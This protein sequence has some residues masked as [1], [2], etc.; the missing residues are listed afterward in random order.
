LTSCRVWNRPGVWFNFRLNRK[1]WWCDGGSNGMTAEQTT[2]IVTDM[3]SNGI[4]GQHVYL[5][6]CKPPLK[7]AEWI[8]AYLKKCLNPDNVPYG[9]IVSHGD[10][11][12]GEP[13]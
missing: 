12:L 8:A 4:Y 5:Y 3:E 13:V 2:Q 6:G 1:M 10:L 7:S 11:Q 9:N